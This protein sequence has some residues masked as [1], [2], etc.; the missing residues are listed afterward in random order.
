MTFSLSQMLEQTSALCG[1]VASTLPSHVVRSRF[2]CARNSANNVQNID[3]QTHVTLTCTHAQT[4]ARL[5]TTRARHRQRW[6][7]LRR[8][9]I[10]GVHKHTKCVECFVLC[11]YICILTNMRFVSLWLFACLTDRERERKTICAFVR[12]NNQK[13]AWRFVVWYCFLAN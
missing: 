4:C 10:I 3:A 1:S 6:Q 9:H 12:A 11:T 8:W 2:I 13:D 5:C 7:R